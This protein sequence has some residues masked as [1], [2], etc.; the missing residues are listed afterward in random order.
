MGASTSAASTITQDMAQ[1]MRGTCKPTQTT[2]QKI[3]GTISVDHCDG[4]KVIQKNE[5]G[6]Y[7]DC[8]INFATNAAVDA[9][10][11]AQA[12]DSGLSLEIFGATDANANT[13]QTIKQFLDEKCY[14]KDVTKQAIESDVLCRFSRGVDAQQL[15]LATAKTR[16]ALDAVAEAVEKATSEAGAS[17]GLSGAELAG[18][19]IAVVVVVVIILVVTIVLKKKSDAK[20]AAAGAGGSSTTI[21]NVPSAAA[22]P[23]AAVAAAAGPPPVTVPT[24]TSATSVNAGGMWRRRYGGPSSYGG[25]QRPHY[26]SRD[27]LVYL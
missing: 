20:K 6:V 15:N 1:V 27:H 2:D 16:C 7:F 5:S 24:S 21:V 10:N 14:S 23:P 12:K 25:V 3:I 17:H 11:R 8:D 26:Y 4:A 19:I 9:F 22:A 18:I 13:E